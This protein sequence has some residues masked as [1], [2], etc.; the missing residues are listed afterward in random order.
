[1][2]F[3]I[4]MVVRNAVP[5]PELL[6]TFVNDT[7]RFFLVIAISALGVKT[8]LEKLFAPGVKGLALITVDTLFLLGQAIVFAHVFL[9]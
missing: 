8:S 5:L 1:M 7:S 6:L 9:L 4:L 3:I 2:A